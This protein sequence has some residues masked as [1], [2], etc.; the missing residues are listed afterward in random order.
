MN[1]NDNI[2]LI[3]EELKDSKK[4]YIKS[5]LTKDKKEIAELSRKNVALVEAMIRHDSDYSDFNNTQKET[6]SAYWLKELKKVLIDKTKSQYTYQ[7]IMEKCVQ[8][9][10][11]ENSTHLN[12]DQ[13]GRQQITDRLVQ[14]DKKKLV[15]YLRNPKK[16]NYKLIDIISEKTIVADDD[17]K[18]RARKNFSF[19]TKFCHYTCLHLFEDSQEQD[20]FSI[21]DSVVTKHLAEY[22]K[23]FDINLPKDYKTKYKVYIDLIDAIIARAKEPISRNGFD[24]LLW[25]F[26]KAR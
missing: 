21:Y 4:Y 12:A 13:V 24:H 16:E 11:S 2:N 23:H 10:D 15:E 20:N 25:Y 7:E 9:I 14:L 1:L 6:S 5:V 17:N 22:A 18:H 26:H 3:R 8:Y 19:A